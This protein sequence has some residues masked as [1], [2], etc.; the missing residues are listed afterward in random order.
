M[1]ELEGQDTARLA[2]AAAW[3]H[4]TDQGRRGAF[5]AWLHEDVPVAP[6]AATL[7]VQRGPALDAY[8]GAR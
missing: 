2:M 8:I 6:A 3:P 4:M 5:G 7:T 1:G